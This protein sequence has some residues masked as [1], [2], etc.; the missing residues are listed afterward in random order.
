MYSRLYDKAVQG[1]N[2]V[3]WGPWTKYPPTELSDRK[4]HSLAFLN[5]ASSSAMTAAADQSQQ[6]SRG[7]RPKTGLSGL[8]PSLLTARR[9]PLARLQLIS[10]GRSI[11][12]G[13]HSLL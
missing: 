9:R 1:E 2:R 4:L 12:G 3:P 13:D 6:R 7:A 5:S 10:S 11:C 8:P